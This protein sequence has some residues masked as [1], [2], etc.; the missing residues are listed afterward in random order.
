MTH[1]CTITTSGRCS[2]LNYS[3]SNIKFTIIPE[4]NCCCC[5]SNRDWITGSILVIAGGPIGD[6]GVPGVSGV[7][8]G[9]RDDVN[10]ASSAAV[11]RLS[12]RLG[13]AVLVW[14]G[15]VLGDA[16]RDAFTLSNSF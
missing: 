13:A 16:E 4:E 1:Q 15:G 14:A 7:S 12:L 9:A 6:W 2:I 11:G 10:A 8:N 5:C 3:L